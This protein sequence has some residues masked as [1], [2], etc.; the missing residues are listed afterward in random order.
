VDVDV[1]GQT[2]NG[3]TVI[4]LEDGT[5][6][7]AGYNANGATGNDVTNV[8]YNNTF[9]Y[10][11]GFEPGSRASAVGL[12]TIVPINLLSGAGLAGLVDNT[13]FSQ[14]WNWSTAST[15]T[16]LFKLAADVLTSGNLFQVNSASTE[17]TGNLAEINLTGSTASTTGNALKVSITNSS[18]TAAAILASNLGSGLALNVVGS[19]ALQRGADYTAAGTSNDAPIANSSLVRLNTSGAAQTITGIANGVDGK[20]LTLMNVAAATATL[21]NNS[22][23]SLAANRILTGMMGGASLQVGPGQSVQLMYD[24]AARDEPELLARVAVAAA[25]FISVKIFPSTPFAIPVIVCAAPE[26]FSRTKE[27]LAIGASLLV[28]AAV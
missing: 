13:N 2:T 28:P 19:V 18:S 16:G 22:G 23:S 9:K 27:E 26:V 11:I 5:M 6:M 24:G 12:S 21:A 7:S 17:L 15:T 14:F 25:T 20:I 4:V 1:Y 3:V 10:V 8:S